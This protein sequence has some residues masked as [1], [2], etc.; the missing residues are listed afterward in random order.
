[1]NNNSFSR[2][3]NIP[4]DST[5]LA[6]NLI[7]RLYKDVKGNMW[8]GST[9]GLSRYLDSTKTFKNYDETDGLANNTILGIVEDNDG[10]LWIGT[11]SEGV[12]RFDKKKE[13]LIAFKHR[14]KN[15]YPV[16]FQEDPWNTAFLPYPFSPYPVAYP[17]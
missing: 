3:N 4:D 16:S 11:Y 17:V 10:Y 15:P 8:I 5:S 13:T 1:M 14:D 6:D 2:L 7:T 9:K 12:A